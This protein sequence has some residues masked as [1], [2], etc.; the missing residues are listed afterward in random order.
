MEVFPDSVAIYR[1]ARLRHSH[2]ISGSLGFFSDIITTHQ[3]FLA[4]WYGFEHGLFAC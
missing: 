3:K 1:W 2:K 4:N